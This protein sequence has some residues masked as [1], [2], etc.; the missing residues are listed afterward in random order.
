VA[1]QIIVA[2]AIVAMIA[3]GV[4]AQNPG[5]KE[6]I[7]IQKARAGRVKAR[8]EKVHYTNKFDIS[9]LPQYKPEQRVTGTIRIWG[10]NYLTDGNLAKYWEDGFR[11]YHPDIKIEWFTPTALVAIP[12][13]YSGQAD[14]GA[15]RHI[16]FDEL[17]TFQRIFSYYPIEIPMVTGSYDVPGWAPADTIVVNK[18]NPITKL[19]FDQL[20][21]IFGAERG[22]G[23]DGTSWNTDAAR[24]PEKNIRTWGQLG[25]TGEWKD[26]P[27][28]VYGRP[29][30]Y[31][32][33]LHIERLIFKGGD[34]WNEKLRE[35]AHDE[36]TTGEQKVSTQS[37]LEDLSKD[38]YGIAYSNLGYPAQTKVKYLAVAEKEAGPYVEMTIET[39]QNRTY[40]LFAEEYLYINRK[41]GQP[42][43]PK[44]KEFLHYV[45]S[46]EGQQEVMRDGKFLPLTAAVVREQRKKLE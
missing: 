37:L 21:G 11:K 44:V 14:I 5:E 27:I 28:N 9:A 43:D 7:D 46:Q 26:K 13:L 29:L 31:H 2:L 39:I 20:D 17:L 18:E 8:G 35:Y 1:R 45:L 30:K 12:G 6:A 33:Q 24:G 3:C 23:W 40:P 16:T 19:T 15:S 4:L 38:K 34:K 32:Q 10:L 42:V 22:G 36:S 25:L 41:P